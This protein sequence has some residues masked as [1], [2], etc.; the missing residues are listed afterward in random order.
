[1]QL[2]YDAAGW[3]WANVIGYVLLGIGIYYTI[4]LGLPQIRHFRRAIHT[5]KESLEGE[6]GGVSGFGALMAALGG[7][8]GTGSLV[9]VSSALAAGGPGA[10]FWMW[11]TAV[12]GMT[13]TFSEAVLGQLFK[14]KDCEGNY[15]G[16]PAYYIE[17]GLR[18]KPIAILI[19]ILYVL[20]IG[21]A[22][23]SLQTN[24]IANAFTGVVDMDPI[25]PGVIVVILAYIVTIGGIK[26]LADVTSRIVPL[27]VSVYF[28]I[29][30]YIIF[31][32]ISQVSEIF[33]SIFQSAFSSRA[34]V[35]G[36]IGW[37]VADAFRNGLARGMFSN[38]AGNG[39]AGI[40]HAS[41]DV[42]HPVDQGLLGM[43]G[44]F[45]TTIIICTCTAMAILMTGVLD[46]G[47]D[48]IVLLQTAFNAVLGNFGSWIVFLAMFLF[49]F[50]TLLADIYY[51]ESNLI[52]VFKEKN[53]IPIWIYRTVLAVILIAASVVELNVIWAAVDFLLGIIVF[54][55]VFAIM[56]L[57]KYVKYTYNH[58]FNQIKKGND[59]PNWDYDIDITKVDLSNID[60]AKQKM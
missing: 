57:S 37:T 39:V 1:M 55:N 4:K 19:S 8:L 23:A 59:K 31:T 22:I 51:G 41:A 35:G 10:I 28:I 45:I 52:Y 43:M 15:T 60:E 16:G 50:T 36:V 17:K 9:G 56:R 33:A 29:I 44:T 21:V 47:H 58:Y 3:L 53:K 14:T 6:E 2:L 12:F 13:V 54:V 18:N 32:N 34:A 49:G 30:L 27:M 48:G 7:Q 11:M 26:R 20:G 40:M 42:K 25:I 24:S 46:S 5:M 38:D